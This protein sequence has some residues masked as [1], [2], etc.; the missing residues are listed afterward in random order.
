M[1]IDLNV[2]GRHTDGHD[3]VIHSEIDVLTSRNVVTADSYR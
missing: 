1:N 2:T 3:V